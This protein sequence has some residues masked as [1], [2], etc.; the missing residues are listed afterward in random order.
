M[1]PVWI[2]QEGID[3]GSPSAST[4]T[5]GLPQGS[6][7]YQ[8]IWGGSQGS[9]GYPTDLRWILGIRG[10][11]YG[12]EEKCLIR[13]ATLQ[14]RW[15]TSMWQ[16]EQYCTHTQLFVLD[17]VCQPGLSRGLEIFGQIGKSDRKSHLYRKGA[18][19][20]DSCSKVPHLITKSRN[21]WPKLIL[22]I[23]CL[24]KYK[25]FNFFNI[26]IMTKCYSA[27]F[28][29]LIISARLPITFLVFNLAN[30]LLKFNNIKIRTSFHY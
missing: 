16:A 4:G 8:R 29:L 20:W 30:I 24:I 18:I 28:K 9:K 14:S 19:R 3:L 27:H 17:S 13:I 11:P 25:I 12:S 23:I 6:E 10:L 15:G 22:S 1:C 21:I 2:I 5:R 7:G 26:Y